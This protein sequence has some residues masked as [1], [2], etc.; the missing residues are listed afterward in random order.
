LQE[1]TNARNKSPAKP[2]SRTK[3]SEEKKK[4]KALIAVQEKK[5]KNGGRGEKK[6]GLGSLHRHSKRG[7]GSEGVYKKASQ[8][9]ASTLDMGRGGIVFPKWGEGGGGLGGGRKVN[10]KEAGGCGAHKEGKR[11]DH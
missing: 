7:D 5:D 4:E 1:T 8:G 3:W 6:K 11:V 9:G 10:K 2:G